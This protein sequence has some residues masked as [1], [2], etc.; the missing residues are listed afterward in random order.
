M[1]TPCRRTVNT[2]LSSNSTPTTGMVE[3][4]SLYRLFATN[5]A[6]L[7]LMPYRTVL[8][9]EV[10]AAQMEYL[11]TPA[12]LAAMPFNVEALNIS[13]LEAVR[14][15]SKQKGWFLIPRCWGTKPLRQ[16]W[17]HG[18]VGYTAWTGCVWILTWAGVRL[19]SH[20]SWGA[21]TFPSMP[22]VYTTL[23]LRWKNCLFS[24]P[25][26]DGMSLSMELRGKSPN[27]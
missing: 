5:W 4:Y 15:H 16:L 6:T 17:P 14:K 7:I 23:R 19:S 27:L 8:D 22:V 13:P 20:W 9:H 12:Q 3:Q 11:S 21:W 1:K 24:T 2:V 26:R 25:F 10:A 18:I